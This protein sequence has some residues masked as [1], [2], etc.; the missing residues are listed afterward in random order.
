MATPD[1]AYAALAP[2][3]LRQPGKTVTV[4]DFWRI[5]SQDAQK[6]KGIVYLPGGRCTEPEPAAKR[7]AALWNIL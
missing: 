3:E 6:T 5:L 2:E 1:P 7:L 4:L